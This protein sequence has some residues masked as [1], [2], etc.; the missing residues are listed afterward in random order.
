MLQ[1]KNLLHFPSL[2]AMARNRLENYIM[3]AD[4]RLYFP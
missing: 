4:L 1:I 3:K 2:S